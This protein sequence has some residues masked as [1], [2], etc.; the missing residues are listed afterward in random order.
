MIITD[1]LKIFAEKTPNKIA[2]QELEDIT[3]KEL[4]KRI[5]DF[6]NSPIKNKTVALLF[7]ASANLL[8][9]SII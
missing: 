8:S 9:W 2:V 1:Y 5:L 3:Y 6:S 4:H 7:Q